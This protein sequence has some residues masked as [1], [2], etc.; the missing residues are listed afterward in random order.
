MPVDINLLRTDK[1]TYSY[2]TL[3]TWVLI[4][5]TIIGGDPEKVKKS[6]R[7]R[8]KDD[9]IVDEILAIDN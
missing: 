9:S 2:I 8:F 1:G 7:D 3:I 4:R 6:Q 5:I